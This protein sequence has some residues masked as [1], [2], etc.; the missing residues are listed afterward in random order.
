[1]LHTQEDISLEIR[2]LF[3][4]LMKGF[5]FLL[6]SIEMIANESEGVLSQTFTRQE[7]EVCLP[8]IKEEDF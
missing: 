3:L 7:E 8:E 1:M 5:F 2:H 4:H 6:P